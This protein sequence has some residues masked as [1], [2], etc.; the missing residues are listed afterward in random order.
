MSV[1]SL[2]AIATAGAKSGGTATIPDSEKDRSSSPATETT[3]PSVSN[4]VSMPTNRTRVPGIAAPGSGIG[5]DHQ[6]SGIMDAPDTADGTIGSPDATSR[7]ATGSLRSGISIAPSGMLRHTTCESVMGV[8]AAIA[9][10]ANGY[11][12]WALPLRSHRSATMTI[13]TAT[14]HRRYGGR[15]NQNTR[16]L[17]RVASA[18]GRG[19]KTR[20]PPRGR[21]A[22]AG[23]MVGGLR[24]VIHGE[25]SLDPH[26]GA[27]TDFAE[28]PSRRKAH[29]LPRWTCSHRF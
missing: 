17:Y 12:V 1:P 26:C 23:G 29:K 3:M 14:A 15:V 8:P 4:T 18:V 9:L 2:A 10:D 22:Q 5:T 16:R 7:D 19:L 25:G 11:R 21:L 28:E 13:A 24:S 27:S 6:P 20:P